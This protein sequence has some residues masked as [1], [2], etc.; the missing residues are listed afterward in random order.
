ML[1]LIESTWPYRFTFG[2]SFFLFFGLLDWWRHPADPRRAREYLFLLATGV[3]AVVYGIVHDHITAT[4]SHAYFAVGKELD[5][6]PRPFRWA[7]TVLAMKASFGPGLL[8]GVALLLV[9][10]PSPRRPQLPYALLARAAAIPL[11]VAVLGAVLFAPLTG[12]DPLRLRA[13]AVRVLPAA[14]VEAFLRVNRIHWGS[15]A[16]AA[17]GT[18]VACV[19]ARRRRV[20]L[21]PPVV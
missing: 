5:A 16:G 11:V 1:E 15:Y 9:N 8:A 13:S 7:V 4:I 18:V 12:I 10:N 2:V 17:A 3:V 19:W 20:R 14:D 21:P 6:D